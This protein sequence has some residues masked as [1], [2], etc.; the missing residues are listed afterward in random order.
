MSKQDGI[1]TIQ[2][3]KGCPGWPGDKI[4]NKK[5]VAVLECI[6][7]IPCNPCETV[8]PKNAIIVGSP[9][10][11][12][13]RINGD[14]CDGCGLCISICPGLAIFVIEKEYTETKSTISIPYE[15]LPL[16]NK[17][18]KVKAFNRKGNYVCNAVV[19]RVATSK[20]FDKT[21]VVTVVVDKQY[22]NEI[23]S[24]SV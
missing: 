23:R 1:L 20:K 18:E 16:P 13:P 15:L 14:K 7:D 9:I 22:F 19:D 10:T 11:N 8:C 2:E 24:I 6:E 3:I 5:R 17:G 4:V 12:L 21:N